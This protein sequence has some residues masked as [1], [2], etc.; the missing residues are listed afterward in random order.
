MKKGNQTNISE[1]NKS[2]WLVQLK[3]LLYIEIIE[4]NKRINNKMLEKKDRKNKNKIKTKEKGTNVT[5][6][7]IKNESIW[8]F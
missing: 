1:N 6:T 4:E 8:I 7:E 3:G 2:L 5:A